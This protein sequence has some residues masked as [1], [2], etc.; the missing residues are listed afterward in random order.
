METFL[1]RQCTHGDVEEVLR[2]DGEWEQEQIAYEFTFVSREELM[3]QL[4]RFPQ[5]FLVAE[6]DG[7]L[8]GYINGSVRL[9][10]EGHPVIPEQEPYLEIENLYVKQDYRNRQIGGRLMERLL[11]VAGQHG[12]QRFALGSDSREMDRVLDFYR[13]FGFQLWYVRMFR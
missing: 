6:C 8:A 13:R 2:L 10:Q 1:I 12:I 11:E 3:A 7:S 4:E 9:G 5:Y